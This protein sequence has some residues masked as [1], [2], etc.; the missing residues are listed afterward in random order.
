MW[1]DSPCPT[2]SLRS[3]DCLA[4]STSSAV[5]NGAHR[6]LPILSPFPLKLDTSAHVSSN[7]TFL[8]KRLEHGA[9]TLLR[10]KTIRSRQISSG[11]A[12]WWKTL[13]F[14]QSFP[15]SH[16][17]CH[18]LSICLSVLDGFLKACGVE[19]NT[20]LCVCENHRV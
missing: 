3:T 12:V 13:V 4:R 14:V 9:F 10:S 20:F 16:R 11:A 5:F 6:F 18:M 15:Q 8:R 2:C 7:S 19:P 1:P 17:G